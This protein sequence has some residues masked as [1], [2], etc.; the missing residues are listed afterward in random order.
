MRHS[1][2]VRAL[3]KSGQPTTTGGLLRELGIQ[4]ASANQHR[5]AIAAWLERNTANAELK[6][7][8][9]ANG[10]GLLLPRPQRQAQAS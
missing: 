3:D 10:Y 5:V 6:L 9:R 2:A 4:H 1:A 7:S 8:L